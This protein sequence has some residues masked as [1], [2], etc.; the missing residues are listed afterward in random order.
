MAPT[1]GTGAW[2]VLKLIAWASLFGAAGVHAA[3][4]ARVRSRGWQLNRALV[5]LLAAL[6]L[7]A[8]LEVAATWAPSTGTNA[9]FFVAYDLAD[10][11]FVA[12]LMARARARWCTRCRG[13]ACT[14]VH[15]RARQPALARAPPARR[16]ASNP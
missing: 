1:G 6:T 12:L 5:A 10:A 16:R 15:A 2:V 8:A 7:V 14:R 3:A 9:A 13:A 4:R 11:C